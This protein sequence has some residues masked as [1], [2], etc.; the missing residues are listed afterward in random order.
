MAT[1]DIP[2]FDWR[3]LALL[4]SV[5]FLW[6]VQARKAR[7]DYEK[8]RAAFLHLRRIADETT[9]ER[10]AALVQ[11]VR[12][13]KFKP[14]APNLPDDG[15][16][17]WLIWYDDDSHPAEVFAGKGCGETAHRRYRQLDGNFNVH[18]F[19]RVRLVRH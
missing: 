7:L 15:E 5:L 13:G 4:V 17:V 18:L 2:P 8:M 11:L 16:G 12:A 3:W 1:I 6:I 19:Q 9:E 14:A 10:D